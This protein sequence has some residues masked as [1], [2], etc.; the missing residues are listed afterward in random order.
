MGRRPG[1]RLDDPRRRDTPE[2]E[3]ARCPAQ[4]RG[5]RDQHIDFS[6]PWIRSV[7][8]GTTRPVRTVRRLARDGRDQLQSHAQGEFRRIPAKSATWMRVRAGR[9][10]Y[11]YLRGESRLCGGPKM[12]YHDARARGSRPP[13]ESWRLRDVVARDEGRP[14]QSGRIGR[15]A[16]PSASPM[17]TMPTATFASRPVRRL[18]GRAVAARYLLH[19]RRVNRML[20][21]GVQLMR[22]DE[23]VAIAC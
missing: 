15:D 8:P 10:R 12:R 6:R 17:R 7:R 21:S 18:A 1:R 5:R 13:R 9:T 3:P 16:W 22:A 4:G 2:E 23:N 14:D 11:L 20:G 19:T